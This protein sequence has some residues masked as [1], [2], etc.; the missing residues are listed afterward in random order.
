MIGQALQFGGSLAAILLLAWLTRRLGLG[1]DPQLRDAQEARRLAGEALE[2]FEARDVVLDRDGTGALLRDAAG[3]VMVLRRHGARWA[4][5]LLDS[6]AAVRI[7]RTLLT[8]TTHDKPFG[9]VTLDLGDQAQV[10]ADRLQPP[11]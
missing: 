4:G 1:G 6:H 11:R 8:I 2:G 3:R 10:W 9:A 7:D 5:R